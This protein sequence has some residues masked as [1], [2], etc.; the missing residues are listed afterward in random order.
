MGVRGATWI[1]FEKI[2]MVANMH[3]RNMELLNK[4][5]VIHPKRMNNMGMLAEMYCNSGMECNVAVSSM[6]KLQMIKSE[7]VRQNFF[8]GNKNIKGINIRGKM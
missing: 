3:W 4:C 5:T 8:I 1:R 7:I 6:K 2:K